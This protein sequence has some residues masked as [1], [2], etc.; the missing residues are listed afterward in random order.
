MGNRYCDMELLTLDSIL[1]HK[2]GGGRMSAPR[3]LGFLLSNWDFTRFRRVKAHDFGLFLLVWE[4]SV[5]NY[6]QVVR[7]IQLEVP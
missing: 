3:I 4:H 6:C 2:V 5:P 1:V 7:G